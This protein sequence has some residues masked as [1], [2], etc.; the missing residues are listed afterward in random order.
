M[1]Y[2]QLILVVNQWLLIPVLG[3]LQDMIVSSVGTVTVLIGA[4]V[5]QHTKLVTVDISILACDS[6]CDTGLRRCTGLFSDS[7][8][9]YF[10][11]NGQ[12]TSDNCTVSSGPNYI[13]TASNNFTC[14]KLSII[15]III[16]IILLACN[17]T[18]PAGHIV[19]TTSCNEC[20]FTSI[21]D[22]DSPC[23][24]GGNCIQ[25]LPA[26]NYTCNCT[27]TGYKGV[28]CTGEYLSF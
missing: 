5:S 22:R 10:D 8:F 7:C 6:A 23:H 26:T 15:I 27:D 19:N 3:I 28:N 1:V 17:L 13:A 14:S 21:C 9:L 18:C 16:I 25:Y 12:C 20:I 24:N 11:C 2:G 4:D